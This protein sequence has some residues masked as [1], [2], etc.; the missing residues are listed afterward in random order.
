MMNWGVFLEE[1]SRGTLRDPLQHFR[2]RKRR[3]CTVCDFTGYFI[4][5]G[6][7]QEIR[8]P[9]CSSKERDRI[10]AMHLKKNNM[11]PLGKRVLHFSA[12]RPFWRLWNSLPDYVAGDIK[13][14]KVSN[15]IVDITKIQFGDSSFDWIICNHVLE[16]VP[17]DM[18]A[19]QECRRVLK[20]DEVAFFSVP[21]G[22]DL[23]VTWNPPPGTP[24][25]EIQR[26]CGRT[27]VR[28][29][30]ADFPDLLR[31]A[32]FTIQT[33]LYSPAEAELHRL[34]G[35]GADTVFVATCT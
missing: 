12:E 10:L 23:A 25:E 31:S 13:K 4:S 18:L 15:T 11:S 16:H 20:A 8:C 7:R 30:G 21:L 33:V 34:S 14:S 29:Y 28:L 5:A 3:N 22:D 9:N 35:R 6:K 24:K 27:H 32:G 1:W 2:A 26:I 17:Q 19:M